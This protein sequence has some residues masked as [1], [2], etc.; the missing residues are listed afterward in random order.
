MHYVFCMDTRLYSVQERL[1][2][3]GMPAR[4]TLLRCQKRAEAVEIAEHQAYGTAR[5]NQITALS[6]K[7]LNIKKRPMYQVAEW[8][9]KM[10][11]LLLTIV[12]DYYMRLRD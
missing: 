11:C 10:E 7:T 6:H 5:H 4:H 8:R 12:I 1:T 2:M 3:C 9:V